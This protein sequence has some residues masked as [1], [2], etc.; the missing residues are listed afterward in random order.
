MCKSREILIVFDLN[1][2]LLFRVKNSSEKKKAMLANWYSPHDFS[3][4]G[5]KVYRR[6]HLHTLME[7]IS[8]N[9]DYQYAVWTSAEPKNAVKLAEKLF[10]GYSKQPLFVFDRTHCTNAIKGEKTSNVFKNLELIFKSKR[11]SKTWRWSEKNTIL[12]EDTSTKALMHPNNLYLIPSFNVIDRDPA[13][14]NALEQLARW[15]KHLS[16]LEVVP[17]VREAIKNRIL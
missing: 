14:D 7:T 2:T 12:V 9:N 4:N 16:S 15:L 3:V 8:T 17:D 5:T 6:Q 1:G 10:A 11:L 13:G